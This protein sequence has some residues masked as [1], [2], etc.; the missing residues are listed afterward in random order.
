MTSQK[1]TNW[2]QP[3]N[4]LSSRINDVDDYV[5]IGRTR[6]GGSLI[7]SNGDQNFAQNLV[8]NSPIGQEFTS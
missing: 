4:A 1:T 6:D 8:A 7:M 3:K 2:N 5:L